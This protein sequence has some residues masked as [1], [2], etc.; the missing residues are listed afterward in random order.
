MGALRA[1]WVQRSRPEAK[2]WEQNDLPCRYTE[3]YLD[4]KGH[5]CVIMATTLI[6]V[7]KAV[8]TARCERLVGHGPGTRP[9]ATLGRRTNTSITQAY[10]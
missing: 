3:N 5:K 10:F 1:T 6:D 8:D 7:C 4:V 9:A 2:R